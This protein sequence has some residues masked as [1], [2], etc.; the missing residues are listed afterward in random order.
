[1]HSSIVLVLELS[2]PLRRESYFRLIPDKP[3]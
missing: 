1:M 2:F 3:D